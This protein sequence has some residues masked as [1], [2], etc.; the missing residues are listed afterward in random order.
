MVRIEN[1]VTDAAPDA[2][3]FVIGEEERKL[4]SDPLGASSAIVRKVLGALK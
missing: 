1:H 4:R 3:Y 2:L